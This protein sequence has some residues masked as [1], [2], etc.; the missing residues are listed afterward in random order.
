MGSGL[1]LMFYD[2]ALRSVIADAARPYVVAETSAVLSRANQMGSAFRTGIYHRNHKSPGVGNTQ[3][4]YASDV[5]DFGG[6]PVG[7]VHPA[8]YA[9]MRDMYENNTLVKAVG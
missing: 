2:E 8:N 4:R 9:A 6:M 1:T 3:A 7:I 5:R